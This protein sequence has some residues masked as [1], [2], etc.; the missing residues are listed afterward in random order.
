[1][2]S[3]VLRFVAWGLADPLRLVLRLECALLMQLLYK[4]LL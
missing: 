2:V 4:D 1:M 3:K